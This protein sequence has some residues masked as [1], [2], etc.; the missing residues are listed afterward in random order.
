MLLVMLL[1]L[2]ELLRLM[3][4]LML[5]LEPGS[6]GIRFEL[7]ECGDQVAVQVFKCFI[8]HGQTFHDNELPHRPDSPLLQILWRNGHLLHSLLDDSSRL[9]GNV[10]KI[11]YARLRWRGPF[12]FLVWTTLRLPDRRD[13]HRN[14]RIRNFLGPGIISW[15]RAPFFFL[16]IFKCLPCLDNFLLKGSVPPA[17][18][19]TCNVV[20]KESK[21]RY[22][23]QLLLCGVPLRSSRWSL[24]H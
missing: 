24:P 14:V 16:E 19:N 9:S 20:H 23:P 8:I 17:T 18:W 13:I 12:P 21:I 11:F 2:H 10:N 5:Q 22:N 4:G 3:L 7:H 6:N 15:S 1:V